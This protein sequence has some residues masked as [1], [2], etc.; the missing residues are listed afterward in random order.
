M[1][2]FAILDTTLEENLA[3]NENGAIHFRALFNTNEIE[4]PRV[5]EKPI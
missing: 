5:G 4:M 2:E 3:F 1:T